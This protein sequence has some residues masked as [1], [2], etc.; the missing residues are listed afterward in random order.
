MKLHSSVRKSNGCL[1][2]FPSWHNALF[3][4]GRIW[5]G[6][7]FLIPG[8]A[9][10]VTEE[11]NQKSNNGIKAPTTPNLCCD[12]FIFR[13][14]CPFMLPCL[15]WVTLCQAWCQAVKYFSIQTPPIVDPR[16]ESRAS[17][18]LTGRL[19]VQWGVYLE[20]WGSESDHRHCA[21]HLKSD[22]LT[23]SPL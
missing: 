7:R 19:G 9:A 1:M 12:V 11:R 16:P 20:D 2:G 13:V 17:G 15:T 22:C 3:S 6:M 4:P 8:N 14:K 23:T 5:W 10:E 18:E 21:A